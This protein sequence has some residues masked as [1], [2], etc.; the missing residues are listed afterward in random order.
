MIKKLLITF[1]AVLHLSI[2]SGATLH[3]Q[4]CMGRLLKVS[5]GHNRAD[6]CHNCGMELKAKATK[7]CCTD[8]HQELK[9]EK[10]S[11]IPH[12]QLNQLSAITLPV[13]RPTWLISVTYKASAIPLWNSQKPPTDT[14]IPVF[15]RNCIFLI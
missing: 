1:L 15:L 13:I 7:D 3:F 11:L 8:K 2:S 6:K 4:Y 9:S 14:G 10:G 12:Y 5:L